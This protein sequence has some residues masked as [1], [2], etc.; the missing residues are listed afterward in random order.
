[1][2]LRRGRP[3]RPRA[4]PRRA[5]RRARARARPRAPRS[6]APDAMTPNEAIQ[7]A[8]S[9]KLLPVYLVVGEERL[10]RD[11]VV[12]ALLAASLGGAVAACNED[13]FT[14]GEVDPD[15]IVSAAR[16]VPMMAPRRFVLVRG[17]ERW[18][19]S[20]PEAAPPAAQT[21]GG[22]RAGGSGRAA[23]SPF[24]RL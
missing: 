2:R 6:A 22:G 4:R 5:G 14:A 1:V 13:K 3:L 10:L 16:T 23:A 8:K 21:G 24:D 19:T 18:D 9:G 15:A 12:D 7:Q 20:D 11:A 17:I